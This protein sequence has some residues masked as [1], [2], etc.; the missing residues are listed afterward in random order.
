[1]QNAKNS[2]QFLKAV[3]V[4]RTKSHATL[5]IFIAKWISSNNSNI[6]VTFYRLPLTHTK[7]NQNNVKKNILIKY[8][9]PIKLDLIDGVSDVARII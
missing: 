5:G 9:L 7:T 1:M 6:D 4:R 8:G 2:S 3:L